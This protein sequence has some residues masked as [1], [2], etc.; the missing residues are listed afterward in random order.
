MRRRRFA[1]DQEFDEGALLDLANGLAAQEVEFFI[2]TEML[3]KLSA[4]QNDIA[5]VAAE[6]LGVPEQGL[7]AGDRR[8]FLKMYEEALKAYMEQFGQRS[9]ELLGVET[10]YGEW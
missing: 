7:L 10:S 1:K 4:R 6:H 8:D 5:E 9:D 3:Q 2:E